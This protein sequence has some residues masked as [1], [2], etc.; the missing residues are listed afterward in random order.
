ILQHIQVARR[1]GKPIVLEEFG[2]ERD[3]ADYRL[4]STTVQRD[5]FFEEIFDLMERQMKLGFPIAGSNFWTWG[6][7]GRSQHMD[8]IWK[9]GDPFTGDPPQ[10]QQGLNSVF[11]V[12]RSTI[13]II[14]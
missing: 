8:L 3:N 4:L 7:A 9:A 2:I 11:D 14:A 6:G 1:L 10:E 13:K 12:D 5:R